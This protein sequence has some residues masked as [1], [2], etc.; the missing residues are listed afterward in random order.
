MNENLKNKAETVDEIVDRI[1]RAK[2]VIFSAYQGTN[3]AQDTK[4][5][6]EMRKEGN[7]YKVYKNRLLIRA[8]KEV[9]IEGC[10]EYLQGTT[11]VAFGYN[12]EVAPARIIAT[13]MKD[14]KMLSFKFGIMNGKVINADE[15]KK[16]S[17]LPSKE[18]LVAKLL[19]VLNGPA[20]G[21]CIALKAISEKEN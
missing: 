20:T 12:D 1:K 5:R 4:L 11:S 17:Q 8:L 6:V 16:I 10:D 2:S 3:V 9:G 19:S 15:V 14:N 7:D 18:V 21:L 13:Q